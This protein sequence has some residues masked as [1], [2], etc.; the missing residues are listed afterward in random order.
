MDKTERLC[1]KQEVAN[2]LL[3]S[4]S[5]IAELVKE[6]L[7]NKIG[8]ELAIKISDNVPYIIVVNEPCIDMVEAAFNRDR[9]TF[10][11][12]A[13]IVPV[14]F[15]KDCKWN[16]QNGGFFRQGGR[17]KCPIQEHSALPLYGFCFLAERSEP[18]IKQP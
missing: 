4:D 9:T 10:R 17:T 13:K 16:A 2:K 12:D 18:W 3:H 1:C 15:C 7:L 14:I 11:T 8:R 6:N 5:A